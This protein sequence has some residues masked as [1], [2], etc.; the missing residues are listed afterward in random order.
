MKQR[1]KTKLRF[2]GVQEDKHIQPPFYK[3]LFVYAD[4]SF[5]QEGQILPET[6]TSV[7]P[8]EIRPSAY[9]PFI[10]LLNDDKQQYGWSGQKKILDTSVRPW[11]IFDHPKISEE[12]IW[13]SKNSS[14]KEFHSSGQHYV[15]QAETQ[16]RQEAVC[17]E[18]KPAVSELSF[19]AQET[20]VFQRDAHTAIEHT[21]AD[22]AIQGEKQQ[23]LVAQ[24]HRVLP[25]A[26]FITEEKCIAVA[27]VLHKQTQVEQTTQQYI[28]VVDH[29]PPVVYEVDNL[30]IADMQTVTE[31]IGKQMKRGESDTVVTKLVWM[32]P[33][34][35]DEE[36][37]PV[38][39]VEIAQNP[40][41]TIQNL[42]HFLRKVVRKY[43]GE[44]SIRQRVV[45]RIASDK[46]DDEIG[47]I[48]EY[49]T[50]LKSQRMYNRLF[51][52]VN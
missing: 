14:Q 41:H 5:R 47:E 1:K 18:V 23:E 34:D 27:L 45:Q 9:V 15:V 50:I 22:S 35:N 20:V 42:L 26:K 4:D 40:N 13:R 30:M 25:I 33:Q 7:G 3:R 39:E 44:D 46:W 31:S 24:T 48:E 17:A 49:L 28:P 10:P 16:I 19:I 38:E 37:V 36:L 43:C 51:A 8:K 52:V 11:I 21:S 2:R 29:A 32:M 12:T 6:H